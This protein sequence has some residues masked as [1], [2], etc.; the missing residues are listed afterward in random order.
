MLCL[1]PGDGRTWANMRIYV[2]MF[3]T[4]RQM[5]EQYLH[6]AITISFHIF[7]NT[8]LQTLQ[9]FLQIGNHLG[10]LC[11]HIFIE[12]IAGLKQ[13]GHKNLVPKLCVNV[14]S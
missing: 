2:V 4:S 5:L 10:G 9:I 1:V 14:R 6:H 13:P 3:S 12:L 8:S 11:I 7:S